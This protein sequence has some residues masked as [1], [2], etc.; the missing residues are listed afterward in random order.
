[1]TFDSIFLTTGDSRDIWTLK[2]LEKN[3]VEIFKNAVEI[4]TLERK[5]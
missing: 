2:I 4:P 3:I 1:M 5:S